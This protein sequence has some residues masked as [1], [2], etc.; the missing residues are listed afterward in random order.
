MLTPEKKK[1]TKGDIPLNK[2]QYLFRLR[3]GL[4]LN[5][6]TCYD[7]YLDLNLVTCYDQYYIGCVKYNRKYQ[8]LPFGLPG[9]L[10]LR[11]RL[12]VVT[13]NPVHNKRWSIR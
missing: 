8:H 10:E 5:F 7:Q 9:M 13:N 3:F 11:T 2:T 4:D 1:E 6:S 12:Q